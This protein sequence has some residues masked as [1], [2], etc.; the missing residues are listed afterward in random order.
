MLGPGFAQPKIS[1]RIWL[2]PVS[3][4]FEVQLDPWVFSGKNNPASPLRWQKV[5]GGNVYSIKGCRIFVQ[6]SG[7]LPI[8]GMAPPKS[9][10]GNWCVLFE[11]LGNSALPFSEGDF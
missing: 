2:Q 3:A 11:S 9:V 8:T 4:H 1:R 5:T 6:Q 7:T 10:S